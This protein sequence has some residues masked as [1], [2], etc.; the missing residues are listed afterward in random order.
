MTLTPGQGPRPAW[1]REASRGPGP[2][3]LAPPPAPPAPSA[4]AVELMQALCDWQGC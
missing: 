2:Q 3:A 4:G 1:D